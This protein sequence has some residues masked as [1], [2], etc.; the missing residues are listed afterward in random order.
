M[1]LHRKNNNPTVHCMLLS[2]FAQHSPSGLCQVNW[3]LAENLSFF[4]CGEHTIN[5]GPSTL[6]LGH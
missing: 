3:C 2:N 6:P 1:A 5:K 4:L